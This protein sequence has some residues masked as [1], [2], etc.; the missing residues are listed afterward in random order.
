MRRIII[1]SPSPKYPLPA[2]VARQR[3]RG[4]FR[5]FLR[6]QTGEVSKVEVAET[7][8]YHLLD[9]A[10]LRALRQWRLRPGTRYEGLMV[11]V[12]FTY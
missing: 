10:A 7:T 12:T 3:G 6:R 1:F 2:R 11:P 9:D 8:G 5:L 4:L